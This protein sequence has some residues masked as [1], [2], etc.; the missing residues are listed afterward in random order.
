MD[1]SEQTR[2]SSH[3]AYNMFYNELFY[4]FAN[5]QVSIAMII[6]III[7]IIIITII[8][9]IIII[10]LTMIIIIIMTIIMPNGIIFLTLTGRMPRIRYIRGNC[11][12]R[13]PRIRNEQSHFARTYDTYT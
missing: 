2:I 3:K 5:I 8:I 11:A 9:I 12:G 6:I 7:L 4:D 13:M 10:I 1:W